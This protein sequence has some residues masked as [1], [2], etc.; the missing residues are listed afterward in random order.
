MDKGMLSHSAIPFYH[1]VLSVPHTQ[2]LPPKLKWLKSG[3]RFSVS[4]TNCHDLDCIKLGVRVSGG[5]PA[6]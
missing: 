5:T 4:F 2:P 6:I 1:P 3:K